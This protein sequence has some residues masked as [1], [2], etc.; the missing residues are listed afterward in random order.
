MQSKKKAKTAVKFNR[1]TCTFCKKP[2]T[3]F[4]P[5]EKHMGDPTFDW[6]LC[7]DKCYGDKEKWWD[8]CVILE[9][10]PDAIKFEIK[11]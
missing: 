1:P 4:A 7:C 6:S 3:M 10:V 5:Q 2:P 11:D 8:G 9:E